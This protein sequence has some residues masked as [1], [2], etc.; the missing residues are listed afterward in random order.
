MTDLIIYEPFK[1][2]LTLQR[3][4]QRY[5]TFRKEEALCTIEK[6]ATLVE[7]EQNLTAPELEEFCRRIELRRNSSTFRKYRTIGEAAD[8]MRP[9]ADKL[10]DNWT[11]LYELAKMRLDRFDRLITSGKLH[12]STTAEELKEAAFTPVQ[13]EKNFVLRVDVTAVSECQQ[14][15]LYQGLNELAEKCGAT[16]TGWP[17]ELIRKFEARAHAAISASRYEGAFS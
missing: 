3:Y 6:C 5:A 7:A 14:F 13:P 16:V 12:P 17:N 8:R 15:E 1:Y 9:H 11:T 10:P 4:V 2:N